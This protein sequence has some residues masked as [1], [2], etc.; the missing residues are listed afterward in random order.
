MS[1]TRSQLATTELATT[2]LPAEF[3]E[4]RERLLASDLRK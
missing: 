2:Q 1:D 4:L 3:A